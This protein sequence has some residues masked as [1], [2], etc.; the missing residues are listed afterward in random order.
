MMM[1]AGEGQQGALYED[2]AFLHCVYMGF[3]WGEVRHSNADSTV[4]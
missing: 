4:H 1:R 2:V 3:C